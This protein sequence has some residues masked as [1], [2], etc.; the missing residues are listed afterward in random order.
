MEKN[1]IKVKVVGGYIIAGTNIDD[2]CNDN[3]I[4][5]L[6]ETDD[7]DII[8][9]VSAVCNGGS[10]SVNCYEDVY[11]EDYTRQYSISVKDIYKALYGQYEDSIKEFD[12]LI[13]GMDLPENRKHDWPWLVRNMAIRN[14]K[15]PNF[16][17]AFAIVK[18]QYKICMKQ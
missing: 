16:Q 11:T 6:F 5:V 4:Y 18:E 12:K 10:V 3:G 8:D 1:E 13:E 7:G 9:V 17:N 2:I 15:H 14:G